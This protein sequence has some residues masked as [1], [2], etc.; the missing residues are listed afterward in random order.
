MLP[1]A[2][3]A[4]LTTTVTDDMVASPSHTTAPS[5]EELSPELPPTTTS[6]AA[7]REPA[8]HQARVFHLVGA[9]NGLHYISFPRHILLANPLWWFYRNF[10]G[11]SNEPLFE[12]RQSAGRDRVKVY[13]IPVPDKLLEI[14]FGLMLQYQVGYVTDEQLLKDLH[15]QYVKDHG[16]LG[17]TAFTIILGYYGFLPINEHGVGYVDTDTATQ[18]STE[19]ITAETQMKQILATPPGVAF[20]RKIQLVYTH[21]LTKSPHWKRFFSGDLTEIHFQFAARFQWAYDDPATVIVSGGDEVHFAEPVVWLLRKEFTQH[22]IFDIHEYIIRAT[23]IQQDPALGT[24]KV[25]LWSPT[26]GAKYHRKI[27]HWPLTHISM[28]TKGDI[29]SQITGIQNTDGYLSDANY[30][31]TRLT[32]RW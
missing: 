4:T 28:Y 27:E 9:F 10:D 12:W 3:T 2:S 31:V 25:D 7:S 15:D 23:L 16:Y 18:A 19:E 30:R 11:R 13:L 24:C 8:W 29:A 1:V 17:V 22:D 20:Q 21:I 26:T 14:F 6:L 5:T 32:L